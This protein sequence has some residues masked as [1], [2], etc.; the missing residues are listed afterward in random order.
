MTLHGNTLEV[1]LGCYMSLFI[2]IN[3]SY[4]NKIRKVVLHFLYHVTI[5]LI[6]FEKAL[7]HFS[8]IPLV[9][10]QLVAFNKA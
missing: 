1:S 2:G 6:T 5:P 3:F 7:I 10:F 8:C 4:M 9:A